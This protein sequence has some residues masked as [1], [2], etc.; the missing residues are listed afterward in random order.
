MAE[1]I[2]AVCLVANV[3]QC[4]EFTVPG[5]STGD[6]VSCIRQAGDK[7]LEWQAENRQYALISWHC[8]KK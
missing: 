8:V 6:V 1:L 5:A 7:A 3:E 4:Q 2:V